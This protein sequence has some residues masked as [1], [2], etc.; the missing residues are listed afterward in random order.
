[1]IQTHLFPRTQIDITLHI[2][3]VDGGLLSACI[4]ATTLALVHA[5]IPMVD[6]I[7]ACTV[8]YLD[9]N[10]ILD[11]NHQEENAGAP[12]L[13]LVLVP[14]TSDI[15]SVTMGSN[16]TRVNTKLMEELL[17]Q[18][19]IGCQKISKILQSSAR[20]YIGASMKEMSISGT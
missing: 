10:C 5:G 19:N 15:L 9:S 4:N 2:V 16:A 13:T 7:T 20:E 12:E 17:R 11:L 3:Q 1:V 8:G 18:A 14:K 6:M